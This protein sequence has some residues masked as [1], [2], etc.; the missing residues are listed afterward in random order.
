MNLVVCPHCKTHRIVT[1][2]VPKDVVVVMPC[3][4]CSE[5][6]VLF[7]K[8]VI[9]LN[10]NILESGT[11]EERKTHL[12]GIIAEFLEPG[13]FGFGAPSRDDEDSDAN[14][15]QDAPGPHGR[16]DSRRL[17]PISDREQER[18]ARIQLERIDD[19]EYFKKHFG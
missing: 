15:E 6:V 3:P 16:R 2:R 9:A 4:G 18:F 14:E 17:P 13:M 1:A 12:A 19:P 10:R 5:L 11:M 8:K 7:R